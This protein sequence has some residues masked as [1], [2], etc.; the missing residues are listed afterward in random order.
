MLSLCIQLNLI[1]IS[2]RGPSPNTAFVASLGTS[3]LNAS[4]YIKVKP[5]LQ[6]VDYPRIFAAGDVIEWPEQ[7]QAAKVASHA[8][9]VVRNALNVLAG[10]S[11]TLVNYQGSP[12]L[13]IITN[14]RVSRHFWLLCDVLTHGLTER[15][16]ELFPVL[17]GFHAGRLLDEAVEIAWTDGWHV[18]VEFGILSVIVS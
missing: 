13:I 18:S 14:G 3:T 15:W 16:H 5:T 4:G 12:E 10:K 9:V 6:L 8:G 2:A 17:R 7:K 11:G 1:Q